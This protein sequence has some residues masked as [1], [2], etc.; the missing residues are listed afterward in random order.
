MEVDNE[1][2]RKPVSINPFRISQ[3]LGGVLALQGIYQS[4]PI[5][6]GAQGCVE[7]IRTVLSRH[8]REP[9]S[10]QSIALHEHNLIFGGKES[11]NEVIDVVVSEHKP[12][13]IAVIGTSLTEAVGEDLLGDV[14]AYRKSNK[15]LLR[16]KML[17]AIYLTDYQGS[18]ESGYATMVYSVVKEIV[19]LNPNISRKKHKNCI[20]LLPGSHLTPGDVMELK[21]IIASFGLEVIVLPD[22]SS[23]LTGHLMKGYTP[24]SRG[25]VPFDYL[26]EI[27]ASGYT[28]AIGSSMEPSAKLLKDALNI[29]YR[30]FNGVTGLQETDDFFSFLQQYSR[31]ETQVKYRWQRQFLLDCMLDTRSVFRGK[32]IIAALEADHLVSLYQWLAEMGVK[33]LHYM[34]TI[35]SLNLQSAKGTIQVDDLY[36]LET[37]A[38]SGVDLWIS[39]SNGERVARRNKTPFIPLGFP[40]FNHFG[41]S[42]AVSVGYRGTA[43][44]IHY[45]GN[46]L[47]MGREGSDEGCV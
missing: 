18:L 21:E 12:D 47:L 17:F 5:I 44:Q 35:P 2:G 6:H 36:E 23:S 10:I 27:V 41:A 29:P 43:E 20:N 14:R 7:S 13:V 8:Y 39:N 30:V 32:R 11:I 16:D 19:E 33:S 3:S 9:I 22:L 1:A 28:I 24:L 25:G 45:L 37:V 38:T 46:T 15:Y 42:F 4:M 34:I 31:S 26:K 40:V